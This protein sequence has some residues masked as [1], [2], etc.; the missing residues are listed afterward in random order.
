MTDELVDDFERFKVQKASD[1]QKILLNYVSL[2]IEHHKQCEATWDALIPTLQDMHDASSSGN[3]FD[4]EGAV[5][6]PI[7]PYQTTSKHQVCPYTPYCTT[8]ITYF[9]CCDCRNMTTNRRV[10]CMILTW[11]MRTVLQVYKVNT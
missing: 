6:P 5:V 10:I 4:D 7:P 11:M 3:P 9:H 2:Q 8:C 1:M